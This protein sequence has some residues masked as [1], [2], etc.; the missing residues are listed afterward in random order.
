MKLFAIGSTALAGLMIAT[1]SQAGG[2]APAQ[3]EPVVAVAAPVVAFGRD[4]T[5]AYGG[6]SLG[7]GNVNASTGNDD[8][9]GLTNALDEA[10]GAIGGIFAGYQYDFGTF[11]L[12]GEIDLNAANLDYDGT[13]LSVDQVHRVKLRAGYDAGKWLPY[14]TVGAAYAKAKNG[15]DLSDT[16]VAYGVGVDYAVTDRVLVGGEFLRHDWDDFD[17][18]D[19][20]VSANTIQARVALRF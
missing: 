16:G 14:A 1:A 6:L 17:G 13:D 10:D 9:L 20:D 2:L 7:Y 15:D 18:T 8:V 11:V 3:P 5:G 4:W 12:G 19:I